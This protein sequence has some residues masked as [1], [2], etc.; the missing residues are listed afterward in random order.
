MSIV[1][2]KTGLRPFQN[3]KPVLT[4]VPGFANPRSK[5]HSRC[6]PN[7]NKPFFT[8]SSQI[9]LPLPLFLTALTSKQYMLIPNS[10]YPFSPHD[11]W[12][13]HRILLRL[14]TSGMH[15]MPSQMMSSKPAVLLFKWTPHIYLTYHSFPSLQSYHIL[16][17][18][19]P[20]FIRIS[21]YT[22]DT[23]SVCIFFHFENSSP[24]C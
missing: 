24:W 15:L 14:T 19:I 6:K 4:A 5:V 13:N 11:P 12:P 22:M 10:H 18:H 23:G 3:R 20:G 8:H 7:S 9:F 2:P 17:F 21:Q 1:Y 16:H